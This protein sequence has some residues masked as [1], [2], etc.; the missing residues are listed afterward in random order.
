MLRRLL[1]HDV[2]KIVEIFLNAVAMMDIMKFWNTGFA[3]SV[4]RNVNNAH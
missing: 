4:L 2:L 1:A 3:R